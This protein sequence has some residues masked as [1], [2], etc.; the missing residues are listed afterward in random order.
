MLPLTRRHFI[1]SSTL[2][3][4]YFKQNTDRLFLNLSDPR[5]ALR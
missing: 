4:I 1:K 5:Q 3:K 2:L